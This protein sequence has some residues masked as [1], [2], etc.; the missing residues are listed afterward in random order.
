VQSQLRANLGVNVA[1]DPMDFPT[2]ISRRNAKQSILFR[3]S[4]QADYDHP[5][6]WFDN[7]FTCSEAA[8]GKGNASGYCNPAVDK[9]VQQAD[10]SQNLSSAISTY[11]EAQRTMINDVNGANLFYQT[12]PYIV[13]TYVKGTGFTGIDD[14]RWEDIRIL[15][16]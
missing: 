2:L 4:W 6:D 13:Q 8:V 16:H 11:E 14:Y 1:L 5:Q 10:T 12:Q 15:E 7:L 9:A 3:E